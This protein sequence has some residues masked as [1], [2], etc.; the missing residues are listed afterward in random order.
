MKR[1][2]SGYEILLL[3]CKINQSQE[4]VFPDEAGYCFTDKA[5]S[6]F[7]ISLYDIR[8]FRFV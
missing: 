8:H 1:R 6:C 7:M 4:E 2:I 3:N 5:L